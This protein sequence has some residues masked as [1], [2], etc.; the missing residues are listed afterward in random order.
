MG[1]DKV[2][3]N[4]A[5][6]HAKVAK[7]LINASAETLV[8]KVRATKPPNSGATMFSDMAS[9]AVGK[10]S[11][12]PYK[13]LWHD[14]ITALTS[15]NMQLIQLAGRFPRATAFATLI[16]DDVL[17]TA[18]ETHQETWVDYATEIEHRGQKYEVLASDRHG[19]AS[20]APYILTVVLAGEVRRRI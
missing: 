11:K 20:I 15:G 3:Q 6:R 14:S 18:G 12:G 13:C 9:P 10:D 1:L 16:L 8:I 5:K 4:S 7:D 17:I 19:M 2:I